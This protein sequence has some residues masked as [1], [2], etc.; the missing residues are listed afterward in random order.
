MYGDNNTVQ[1]NII[2]TNAGSGIMVV[3]DAGSAPPHVSNRISQNTIFN[4]GKVGID[5]HTGA[6]NPALG[7][8]P[9]FTANDV[10]DADGGANTGQNFPVITSAVWNGANT[11]VQGTLNS[12]AGATFDIEVFSNVVCNGDTGGTPQADPYG[13]GQTYRTT[14]NVTDGDSD[15]NVSFTANIPADLTSQF[16]T[17]TASNTATND[18]SEFSQ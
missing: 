16:I 12:T 10:N 18:T 4:N 3:N 1:R 6:E 5:L 13:E 9:F 15:N 17:A 8:A 7:T 11:V 14:V 2:T